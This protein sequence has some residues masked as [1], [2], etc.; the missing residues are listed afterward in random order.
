MSVSEYKPDPSGWL[1][2]CNNIN[3]IAIGASSAQFMYGFYIEY[4]LHPSV[5][6]MQGNTYSRFSCYSTITLIIHYNWALERTRFD[7][8]TLAPPGVH[9]QYVGDQCPLVCVGD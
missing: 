1:S 5:P 3:G 2:N 8:K 4:G 6:A 9:V 7:I